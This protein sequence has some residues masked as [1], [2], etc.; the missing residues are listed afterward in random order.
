LESITE[1]SY[2]TWITKNPN[3]V[4]GTKIYLIDPGISAIPDP[5]RTISNETC[6]SWI[7]LVSIRFDDKLLHG[8]NMAMI[9]KFKYNGLVRSNTIANIQ[10]NEFLSRN[11][12]EACFVKAIGTVV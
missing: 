7:D 6:K 1:Q 11:I 9:L 3:S 2:S 8:T 5:A 10:V 4:A 12:T